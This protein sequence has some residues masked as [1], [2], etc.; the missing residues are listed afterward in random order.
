MNSYK[1][2]MCFFPVE[3]YER[4]FK[5]FPFYGSIKLQE[6]C[7]CYLQGIWSSRRKTPALFLGFNRR[8]ME[9]SNGAESFPKPACSLGKR[10]STHR[11]SHRRASSWPVLDSDWATK[12]LEMIQLTDSSYGVDFWS[13]TEQLAAA[14]KQNIYVYAQTFYVYVQTL[15]LNAEND[16]N[17]IPTCHRAWAD[18]L[19]LSVKIIIVMR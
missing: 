1:L 15:L 9:T 16:F 10:K 5:N 2:W 12:W 6:T 17:R 19:C 18:C 13:L 4:V 3:D 11:G 8:W 14:Q 7:V